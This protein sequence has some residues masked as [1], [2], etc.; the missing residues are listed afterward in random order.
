MVCDFHF[1]LEVGQ[2]QEVG[3]LEGAQQR[4]DSE[5]ETGS[6]KPGREQLRAPSRALQHE[7]TPN[8]ESSLAVSLH[9]F[10]RK[11]GF[12]WNDLPMYYKSRDIQNRLK[13][14]QKLTETREL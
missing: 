1:G 11:E 14:L 13:R 5:S 6:A 4:A 9:N 10:A 3:L 12:T 7:S 2:G 8:S